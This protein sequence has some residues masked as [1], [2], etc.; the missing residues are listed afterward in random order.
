MA[1]LRLAPGVLSV[2]NFIRSVL[3][4]AFV[5]LMTKDE[6]RKIVTFTTTIYAWIV[7]I[8]IVAYLLVLAGIRLPYSIIKKPDNLFYPPFLN[9]RLYVMLYYSTP[10]LFQRFQSIFTEPGHLG[11]ISA[12]L[13]YINQYN[14]KRKRVLV[15]FISMLISFSLAGYVLFGIGF[16]IHIAAKSKYFYRTL[17]KFA[18]AGALVGG[19]GYYY[20]INYPDTA[21]SRL[22]LSRLEFDEVRGIS[23]DNRTKSKFNNHYE[24]QFLTS[25]ENILW[26]ERLTEFQYTSILGYGGNNSYRVFLLRYGSISLILLFLMY[27][28]IAAVKPSRLGFGLLLVYC[29]SF[30]QRTSALWDMQLFLYIGAVQYFYDCSSKHLIGSSTKT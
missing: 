28:S 1:R 13:L 29:A 19:A 16:L 14:F 12:F 5:I 18:L 8:S 6:K 9:Y 4:I 25:T 24:T 15:I 2:F 3:V 17:F 10:R 27:F 26:G 23:G 22:I 21:V 20:Y 30:V 7:G 11:M